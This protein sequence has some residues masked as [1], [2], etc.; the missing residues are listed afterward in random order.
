MCFYIMGY[1]ASVEEWLIKEYIIIR[2][3]REIDW[4]SDFIFST[5]KI[6]AQKPTYLSAFAK[7]LLLIQKSIMEVIKYIT[8]YKRVKPTDY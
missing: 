3:E 7:L 5:V 2:R 1:V 6:T 8:A 4:L